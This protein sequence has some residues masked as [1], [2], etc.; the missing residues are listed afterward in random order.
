MVLSA[1]AGNA[2]ARTQSAALSRLFQSPALDI[3]PSVLTERL[4]RRRGIVITQR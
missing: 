2:A 1:R 3:D 4:Q